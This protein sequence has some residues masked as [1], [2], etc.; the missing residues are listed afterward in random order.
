M[1]FTA[2]HFL[3]ALSE[4]DTQYGRTESPLDILWY[5]YCVASPV[6]DDLIRAAE[7]E[8]NQLAGTLP[9]P[10][11]D[12]LTDLVGRVCLSYQRAAF[13]DGM[14]VGAELAGQLT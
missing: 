2:E 4:Y 3:T 9:L 11:S 7:A 14:K 1:N 10:V 13:L 8:L 6:D 5:C 12:G